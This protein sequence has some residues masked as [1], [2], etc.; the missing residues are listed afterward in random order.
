MIEDDSV[1]VK[2]NDIWN[3]IEKMLSIRFIACVLTMKST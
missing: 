2:Y 1:L 3:I